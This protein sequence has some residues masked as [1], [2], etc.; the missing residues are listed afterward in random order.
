MAL[1]VTSFVLLRSARFAWIDAVVRVQEVL[2][3]LPPQ[4]S[5][6]EH[7]LWTWLMDRRVWY[8]AARM[9][10]VVVDIGALGLAA[11]ALT[12]GK[13]KAFFEAARRAAEQAEEP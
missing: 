7:H 11:L 10:L 5:E 12:R 9:R 1:A 6:G 2:P 4:A 8:W 13:T 3:R